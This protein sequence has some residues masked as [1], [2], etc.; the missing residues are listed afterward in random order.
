VVIFR[1]FLMVI[2]RLAVAFCAGWPE[3]FTCRVK[4]DVPR[5]VGAP[6]I[7]PLLLNERPPGNEPLMIE[8][9]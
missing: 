6:V 1:V 2:E 4:F 9:V 5:P 8:N 3:S 7:A